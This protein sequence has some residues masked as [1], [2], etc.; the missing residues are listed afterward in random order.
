M[1]SA[2]LSRVVLVEVSR[3][4]DTTLM[5]QV[6]RMAVLNNLKAGEHYI[7][8]SKRRAGNSEFCT[9]VIGIM[10]SNRSNQINLRP[11]WIINVAEMTLRLYL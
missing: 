2:G 3:D 7:S 10:F 6:M 11:L 4:A 9:D 5:N 1:K 8:L